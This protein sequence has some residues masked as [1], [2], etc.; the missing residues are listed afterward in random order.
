MGDKDKP[1]KKKDSVLCSILISL[2]KL[3]HSGAGVDH[4][5][6]FLSWDGI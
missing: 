2:N 6:L 5:S 3:L 1:E 4:L